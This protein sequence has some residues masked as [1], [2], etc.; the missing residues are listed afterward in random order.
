MSPVLQGHLG[1]NSMKSKPGL[2]TSVEVGYIFIDVLYHLVRSV[3]TVYMLHSLHTVRRRG[4]AL[5]VQKTLWPWRQQVSRA[6]PL[7]AC[8]PDFDF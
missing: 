7:H 5:V 1:V 8:S 2:Y 3:H 6:G 4:K